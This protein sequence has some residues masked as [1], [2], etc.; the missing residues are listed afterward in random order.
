M[1]LVAS[2]GGRTMQRR[3]DAGARPGCAPGPPRCGVAGQIGVG[4]D[5]RIRPAQHR[6]ELRAGARQQAAARPRCRSCARRDSTARRVASAHVDAPS[7][8]AA[9]ASSTRSTTAPI[10]RL[11]LSTI[12]VRL[13]I[14]RRPLL[15]QLGEPGARI[16]AARAAAVCPG[17]AVRLTSTSRS[18]RSQIE[19][20]LDTLLR[21]T[22]TPGKRPLLAAGDP[23]AT[24][25]KLL[26]QRAPVYAEADL[27]V[28][29]SRGPIGAVV[30]RILEALAALRWSDPP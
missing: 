24:L 22:A 29:S 1:L 3:G 8:C 16:A 14:D 10:G 19:S 15:E 5:D 21:R 26:A 27:V 7:A 17:G 18:A 20:A 28:D 30:D 25:A 4:D 6:P 11:L 23:R 9:S 13:G 12:E 2:P